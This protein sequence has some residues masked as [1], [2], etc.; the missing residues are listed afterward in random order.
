MT[1]GPNRAAI[2]MTPE[3][4]KAYN[5]LLAIQRHKAATRGRLVQRRRRAMKVART[6]A[7]LLRDGF[8]ASKVVLFGSL[9][10]RG[11]FTLW[12]DI[13]LAAWDIPSNKFYAAVAAVTG[14]SSEFKI[15]LVDP[16][17]CR[18]PLRKAIEN[19]GVIL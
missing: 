8:G 1:S 4:W 15:D 6:A 2:D 12:S 16:E 17:A 18:L 7:S 10:P 19:D 14:L 5:P 13:D 9:T 11:G 3:E